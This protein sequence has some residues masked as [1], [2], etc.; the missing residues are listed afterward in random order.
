M[1]KWQFEQWINLRA[2]CWYNSNTPKFQLK[3]HHVQVGFVVARATLTF[4]LKLTV[5]FVF[6]QHLNWGFSN[7]IREA[8]PKSWW[9]ESSHC[10]ALELLWFK[11]YLLRN[12]KQLNS[13][14]RDLSGIFFF[15]LCASF[16]AHWNC[17]KWRKKRTK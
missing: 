12:S 15:F 6:F 14:A 2:C 17:V 3:S 10:I 16:D 1:C 8:K 11:Y 7:G 5:Y 9:I 13:M 4:K